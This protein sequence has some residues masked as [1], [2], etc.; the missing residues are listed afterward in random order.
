MAQPLDDLIR[1][2]VDDGTLPH[3]YAAVVKDGDVVYEGQADDGA[4]DRIYRLASM[5]K[6]VTA[7]ACMQLVEQGQISLDAPVADYLEIAGPEVLE[8]VAADGTPTTRPA[9]RHA[10]NGAARNHWR[11]TL[12]RP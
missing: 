7:V 11:Q 4:R 6:P 2:P 1:R 3:V 12:Y 9:A 5:I 10:T 8:A